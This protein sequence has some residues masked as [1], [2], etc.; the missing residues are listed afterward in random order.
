MSGVVQTRLIR[1]YTLEKLENMTLFRNVVVE[2]SDMFC[3]SILDFIT[4]IQATDK[5]FEP[6]IIQK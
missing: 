3:C 5:V 2:W 4:K 1:I 6:I